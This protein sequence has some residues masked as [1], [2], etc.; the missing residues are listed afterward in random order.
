MTKIH[1]LFLFVCT[2]FSINC[3][4]QENY[5]AYF[6]PPSKSAAQDYRR[7]TTILAASDQLSDKELVEGI[8]AKL[9]A[10][11]MDTQATE[12]AAYLYELKIPDTLRKEEFGLLKNLKHNGA[13]IHGDIMLAKGNYQEAVTYFK[14]ALEH[15]FYSFRVI[16]MLKD[17]IN[18][19]AKLVSCYEKLMDTNAIYA[20]ALPRI[21]S[22]IKL[23]KGTV[24]E[25]Q[26]IRIAAD[27]KVTIKR[28]ID[29]G[30]AQVKSLKIKKNY[31]GEVV[32]ETFYSFMFNDQKISVPYY[33][34]S[35]QTFM[36]EVRET[37]F[38]KSLKE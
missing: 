29:M 20:T 8:E 4:G 28:S 18:I 25:K 2:V 22:N 16:N 15:P 5:E 12:W 6:H 33:G 13:H 26:L 14:N 10:Y 35:A 31:F 17:E 19:A 36:K 7:V 11:Q 23:A 21:L 37:D 32:E 27:D 3:L 9:A 38:Y 1:V 30:L 24:L 34:G